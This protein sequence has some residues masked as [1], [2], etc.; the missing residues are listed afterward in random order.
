VT[1]PEAARVGAIDAMQ[2]D[3]TSAES[4][5]CI[6]NAPVLAPR[7]TDGDPDWVNIGPD[8]QAR[9]LVFDVP[10]KPQHTVAIV[11]DAPKGVFDRALQVAEPVLATFQLQTD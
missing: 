7:R 5:G 11:M 10:G 9:V 8:R 3:V 1:A 6:D 4:T 2:L